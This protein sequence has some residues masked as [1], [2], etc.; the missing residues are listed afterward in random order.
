LKKF[1]L[2]FLTLSILTSFI[3]QTFAEGGIMKRITVADM[4]GFIAFIVFLG[5][6]RFFSTSGYRSAFFIVFAFA[7]G[8]FQTGNLGQTLTE[9]L[10]LLFLI[11]SSITLYS[12]YRSP[13]GFIQLINLIIYTGLITS[14]FG[15]YGFIAMIT[16]LPNIFPGRASGE[17]MSGFRNAGQAGAYILIFLSILLP[18]Y[19][20][21]ASKL[22]DQRHKFLLLLAI[23]CLIIYLF[24]TAKIAAYIGFAF[25][26]ALSAMQR[27]R[28]GYVFV[29]L[30]VSGL[31]FIIWQNLESLAPD[32][33]ER[34]NI[35][36]ETRITNNLNDENDIEDGFIAKNL[37]EALVVF[38]DHPLTGS[39]IGGF[40]GIYDYHEV[41]STYFKIM[42][43]TGLT[44]LIAYT[45]FIIALMGNFSKVRKFKKNNPY[46]DYLWNLQPFLL[47][48]A[49]S[50][51]YTYHLRKREFWILFAVI[52][53]AA[54]LKNKFVNPEDEEYLN[55]STYTTPQITQ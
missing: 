48:C 29:I 51:A 22:L 26:I 4:F 1:S 17:I 10:V 33:Y 14:F 6:N 11:F 25:C 42:G 31:I 7:F 28:Y 12:V 40:Q 43:E 13:E 53:I 19:F 39:G 55:Q 30:I 5:L 21:S 27:R 32:V 9:L 47:G 16:G 54:Y 20:S 44:G 24:L 45:I 8:L 49:V 38:N 52:S 15:F 41:H 35:K 36:I 34:I 50:W 23:Y 18:F 2:I 3:T 37:K 46:A